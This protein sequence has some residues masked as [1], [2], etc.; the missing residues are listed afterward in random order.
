MENTDKIPEVDDC[1]DYGRL[2]LEV[3][4]SDGRRAEKIKITVE[5]P[6]QSEE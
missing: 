4:K 3:V 2:N 1:F 6:E 5:K